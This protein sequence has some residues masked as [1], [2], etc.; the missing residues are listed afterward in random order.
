MVGKLGKA[1][2][3]LLTLTLL[4][5]G[6]VYAQDETNQGRSSHIGEIGSVNLETG[7][8]MLLSRNGDELEFV[9][10]DRTIFRSRNGDIGGLE[11]LSIG[12]KAVVSAVQDREGHRIAILVAAGRVGDLPAMQRFMGLF[13][14]I[15]IEDGSFQIKMKDGEVQ[16]IEVGYRTRFRSRDGSILGLSDIEPGMV[17]SVVAIL[18]EEQAPLALWVGVGGFARQRERFTVVGEIINVVPGQGTFELQSRNGDVLLFS[19]IER[20]KFRSRDGSIDELHDLKKGMHAFVLGLRNGEGG[21]I[22]LGIAAGYPD[23]VRALSGDVIAL[24]RIIS[25]DDR[26]FTIESRYQGNLTFT[27]NSSTIYKSRNSSA[28]DFKDLQVGM[29][30]TVIAEGLGDSSYNAIVVG[31]GYEPEEQSMP[32]L[33]RSKR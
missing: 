29:V 28:G 30:A 26:S 23:D 19:V 32:S 16:E 33:D 7:S 17:G 12:M 13:S 21:Q 3:L 11:D 14:S 4:T 10:T 15:N 20:T 24:G 18:R 1:M 9:V 31:V 6:V 2:G 27:V 8:F 5:T 25:I 22:A